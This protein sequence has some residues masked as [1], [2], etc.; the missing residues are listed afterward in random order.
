MPYTVKSKKSGS[1]YYLHCREQKHAK[2]VTK[3]YFFAKEV[4]PGAID[5]LPE[6]HVVGENPRTGLPFLKRAAAVAAKA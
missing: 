1:I 5:K 2:G 4:K 6:G 3:F